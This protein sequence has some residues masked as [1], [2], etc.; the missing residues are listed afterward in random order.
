MSSPKLYHYV[1]C[2]YCIRVRMAAGFLD[3]PYESHVLKYDDEKTPVEL[4]GKK[5]LP[6]WVD[7]QGKAHPESLDI[8]Q[9]IDAGDKL[10]CSTLLKSDKFQQLQIFLDKAG[11][12]VHNMAM[13]YF[14][15]TPEFDESSRNYFEAKKSVKRGPFKELA[16]KRSEFEPELIQL[17]KQLEFYF[18]PFCLTD[19]L[20]ILDICLAS[21][22][23]G[24][25][26]VP[27]FYFSQHVHFYLQRVKTL[28]KFNYHE[29]FWK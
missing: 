20:T 19:R 21:Q 1:H 22:L 12:L 16:K 6:I 26:V 2:P 24:M 7:P 14:I 5:M 10:E 4:A 29:D 25:Y 9:M 3:I 27:E 13:P 11:A 23:W 15:Y 28:C 18:K 17:L 8:I